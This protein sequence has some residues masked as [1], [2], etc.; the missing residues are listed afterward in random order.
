M[1][2]RIIMLLVFSGSVFAALPDHYQD[3]SAIQKQT[4][5]WENIVSSYQDTGMPQESQ[6]GWGAALKKIKAV[7][8]LKATFDHINDEMPTGRVK[9]IHEQGSVGKIRF[10]P[11]AD[12]PFTGIYQSG[13]LGLARLSLA[14]HPGKSGFVPGM[15]LKFFI[16][17]QPSVNT[18]AM[19]ALE[20]QG[21]NWNY[22]AN[23][24]TTTIGNA[25][26][27]PL[28]ILECIFEWT[29]KPANDLPVSQFAAVS[30]LGNSIE[31]PVSP[32]MLIL[33]PADAVKS[34]IDPTSRADFRESLLAI[35]AGPL[36]EVYG[37][38]EA[39][40]TQVFHIGTLVL[41]SALLPSEYG[42]KQL[43]FQHRR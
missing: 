31:T 8:S 27:L 35:P 29:R 43:F 20:G 41:E 12:H 4:L 34:V 16:N 5:L 1:L 6:S 39:D 32:R 14:V 26:R 21:D 18:V 25:K 36:Y 9:F 19:F 15:A 13:G 28:K 33:K 2:Y 38:Q 11:T 3:L 24:F 7:F 42:D 40:P 37:A 30:M 23:D 22:F 17:G 10:E